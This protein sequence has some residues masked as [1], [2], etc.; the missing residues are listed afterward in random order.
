L[1]F[2]EGF[3]NQ[4]LV[5]REPAQCEFGN[6]SITCVFPG[7]NLEITLH[8]K[9]EDQHNIERSPHAFGQ[10][11]VTHTRHEQ[12]DAKVA[13]THCESA[14]LILGFGAQHDVIYNN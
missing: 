13:T 2:G 12:T 9:R 11:C 14:Q 6:P 3:Q 5:F 4:T 1:F 7:E 8:G 10:C